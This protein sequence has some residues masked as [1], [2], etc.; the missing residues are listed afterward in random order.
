MLW[1]IRSLSEKVIGSNLN[2]A[3]HRVITQDDKSGSHYCCVS[4]TNAFAKT[5]AAHYSFGLQDKGRAI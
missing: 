1:R 2:S 3:Y 5:V 4:R